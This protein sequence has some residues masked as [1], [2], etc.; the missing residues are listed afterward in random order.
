[1]TDS[2]IELVDKAEEERKKVSKCS[3]GKKTPNNPSSDSLTRTITIG[4]SQQSEATFAD[5][6]VLEDGFDAETAGKTKMRSAHQKKLYLS[7]MDEVYN[8]VDDKD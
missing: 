7:D 5:D 4:T 3:S 6:A 2:V 8:E 1:M